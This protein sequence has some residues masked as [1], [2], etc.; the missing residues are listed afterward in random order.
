MQ[1]RMTIDISV[2]GI[3]LYRGSLEELNSRS[4]DKKYTFADSSFYFDKVTG[5]INIKPGGNV[6]WLKS[7]LKDAGYD[8]L[9]NVIL[10]EDLGGHGVNP[11]TTI[12]GTPV[13]YRK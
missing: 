8:G 3:V 5:E 1:T 10:S 13:V 9:V 2:Q 12:Q 11:S 4:Q 6:S 7:E